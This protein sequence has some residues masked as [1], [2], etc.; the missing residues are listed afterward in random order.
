MAANLPNQEAAMSHASTTQ[1]IPA[2]LTLEADLNLAAA[3]RIHHRWQAG[4][5]LQEQDGLLLHQGSLPIPA[6]FM[7]TVMRLDAQVPAT[8]VLRRARAFFAGSSNPFAPVLFMR[9]DVDIASLLSTEGCT[10]QA[11]IALMLTEQPSSATPLPEGWHLQLVEGRGQ[12]PGVASPELPGFV[13]CCAQ[14]Y[15]S[16][17][18]PAFMTPFFFTQAEQVL[19]PEVSLVLARRGDEPPAG[20]AMVLHTGD[21]AGL[22]WVATRPEARG[23]G[24]AAACTV[25]A[26][27][28]ALERGAK[29]VAL[30]ASPMGAPVYRRLGWREYDRLQRWSC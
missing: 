14:A 3:T 30:Q 29:A 1:V 4:A 23:Q 5:R 8:E 21:M 18:L 28:L 7:N 20:A 27:N 11:D 22:Y 24:L 12:A 10:L 19:Q 2:D 16:L 9:R 6:P 17:G 13:A 26:T 25:A 15:A